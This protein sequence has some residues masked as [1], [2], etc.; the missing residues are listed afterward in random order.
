MLADPATC[1]HDDV[2]D[3]TTWGEWAHGTEKGICVDC[4]THLVRKPDSDWQPTA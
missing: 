1:P 2:A 4:G 3:A